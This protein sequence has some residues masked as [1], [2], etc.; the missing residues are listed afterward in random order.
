[1]KNMKIYDEIRRICSLP[2]GV[3][4][5]GIAPLD[6]FLD[7]PDKKKP[8]AF[9]PGTNSVIVIGSQVFRTLTERLKA[10]RKIGEVSFRD[11]YDA[12]VETVNN[13]LSQTGYRI[14]R[15]LTNQGYDSINIG[16]DLTDYRTITGAFSFKYAA[17]QAGLGVIGKNG[18]LLT[19]SYGPRVRL[20]AVLT[21]ATLRASP[22]IT[23]DIC[24]DCDICFKVCPS[25][26]LKKP[27]GKN[28]PNYDRFVCSAYYTANNGCGLCMSKC[29]R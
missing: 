20:S 17:V 11:F 3:D 23:E 5:L 7:L 18:L 1:M 21:E 29:P 14:A 12:H 26:A 4:L 25:K 9:L 8:T 6:R 16:Q 10:N 27:E 13:D 19:R 15:Y 22:L 24:E 2:D 28:R